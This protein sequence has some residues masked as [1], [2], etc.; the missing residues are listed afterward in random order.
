MNPKARLSSSL[1]G[2]GLLAS[3]GNAQIDGPTPLAWRWMQSA[4]VAPS[5]TPLVAGKFVYVSVENRLYALNT[6]TGNE[7]WK[8]PKL[9]P[10]PGNFRGAP[11]LVD[12]TLVVATDAARVYGVDPADGTM[13][14]SYRLWPNVAILGSPV[15]AGGLV[16][17]A[18][19][20][21][22]LMALKPDTGE[23]AWEKPMPLSSSLSGGLAVHGDSVIL[24]NNL[25]EMLSVSPVTQKV[26]W[27]A[28]FE[29]LS[30]GTTPVVFGDLIFVS[31]GPYLVAVN[32]IRGNGRWNVN[33]GESLLVGPAVSAEG[34]VAVS[35][36][37]RIFH[38]DL[39]GRRGMKEVIDLGSGPAVQPSAIGT[40]FLIP[41][42]NGSL[43]LLDP[44]KG[45][46]LWSYVVR[47]IG[48][49]EQSKTAPT[50]TAG[51]V[52][53]NR[54]LSI[55]AA[56]QAVLA[57]STMLMLAK[58]GSLL[59]FD[60]QIGVDLTPPSVQMLWPPAGAQTA[61]TAPLEFIFKV[62]DEAT[63]L[64]PKTL[65]I[66]I[67]GKPM[68]FDVGR[69]GIAVARISSDPNGPNPP[70]SDGRTTITIS[71]AD[72]IGNALTKSYT[73]SIDNQLAPLVRPGSNQP[74]ATG[75]PGRGEGRGRGRGG[76]DG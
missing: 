42:T 13:K 55:P 34:I 57:G 6:D 61:G 38:L 62:D 29:T 12:K 64:D 49:I 45:E 36:Q 5:G 46:I 18:Q 39:N 17:F 51:M 31:S 44:K 76:L 20:D 32:A 16:I 40:K 30:A 50:V 58:D 48:G 73:L 60:R 68:K 70:L 41:T 69:D 9:D 56:G 33:L 24:L 71:V 25:N 63:G 3:I 8:F 75:Q 43:N 7:K 65:K 1:L 59:A 28:R 72:W 47:P 2:L 37:G 26:N 10:E 27:R 22:T 14:W 52:V 21:N 54:V 67:N 4:K 66:D 23:A 53:D 15:S 74:P 35:R 11:I 19:S